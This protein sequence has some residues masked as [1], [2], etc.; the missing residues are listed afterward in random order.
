MAYYP[1]W[2][3]FSARKILVVGGGKIAERKVTSFVG[4]GAD[5]ELI[6]PQITARLNQFV[7]Q[8]EV[9]WRERQYE[10][11]DEKEAFYVIAAT[12]DRQLNEKIVQSCAPYQLTLNVSD[13][14]ASNTMMAAM[15]K[16]EKI[17]VAVST[18]G[19]QPILAKKVR[20]DIRTFLNEGE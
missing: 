10:N 4:L 16:T 1:I 14:T 2:I 19:K 9:Q 5:I 18:N 17:Q 11:G 20:D 3:N 8:G 7:V 15:I 13:H 6:S 12:N